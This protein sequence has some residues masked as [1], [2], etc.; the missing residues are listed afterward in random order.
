MT[1]NGN[2]QNKNQLKYGLLN[3][4]STYEQ[5]NSCFLNYCG[6]QDN[7]FKNNSN[8]CSNISEKNRNYYSFINNNINNFYNNCNIDIFTKGN[9]TLS[10]ANNNNIFNNII[11]SNINN[12]N[13]FNYKSIE[14]NK[15]AL[16][17]LNNCN[18]NNISYYFFN[19]KFNQNN[20]DLDINS[21]Q[22]NFNKI[23]I[24]NE[25]NNISANTININNINKN[26]IIN[27][28]NYLNIT[29]NNDIEK[30]NLNKKLFKNGNKSTKKIIPTIK[31]ESINA[32]KQINLEEFLHYINSLPMPLVN[33]LC[34]SK[35]VFEIRKKLT[36]SNYNYKILIVLLLKKDG[37]YKIM[38]NTYGNYF[39]QQIIKGSEEPIISLILSYIS[40]SIVN[41]SKDPSGTFSMQGLLDEISSTE[42][43]ELI[44]KSIKNHEM[45]MAYNKNATHVLQKLVLLFPDIHRKDLNE[46]ILNNIKN[47]C[48]NQNG[49]CLVKTFIRSNTLI[50]DKNRI[51]K[52]FIKNFIN[53]AEN[54]FGNYGIQF[55]IENWDNEMLKDIKKKILENIYELSV[56]QFSSNVVEKAIEIFD[57]EYRE[58]LIKKLC[59]EGNFLTLL[60]SRFGRFVLYKAVNF[61][62]NELKNKFEE[63]LINNINNELYNNKEKN[64]IKRF[65][66]KIQ[67]W[68]KS[69]NLN[70]N[71]NNYIIINNNENATSGCNFLNDSNDNNEE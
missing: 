59:F 23:N 55:L 61:M 19:D 40:D 35:G 48:V 8:I 7:I 28:I 27:N 13:F 51:N 58:N 16:N 17:N 57:E 34:T 45:E 62:N 53:L 4:F 31:N 42:Q 6:F 38:K 36:K 68:K 22:N 66:L 41:I 39:F 71:N 30:N 25:I 43:E 14:N 47:L 44:L 70:S 54:P 5:N 2:E 37:L 46:I 67:Y 65:L 12:S 21:N 20:L 50:D 29:K 63:L 15:V 52:E 10:K 56:Q 1:I 33:Y 69:S 49:I 60:K 26:K 32:N 64:K 18:N 24:Q 3:N 11:N 9:P